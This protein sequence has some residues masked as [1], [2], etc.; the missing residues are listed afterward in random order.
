[1]GTL[2]NPKGKSRGRWSNALAGVLLVAG[3]ACAHDSPPPD[4]SPYS[5]LVVDQASREST[6]GHGAVSLGY[7]NTYVDGMLLDIPGGK[8]PIGTVRIQSVSLDLDYFFADRWS[9][10]VGLPYVQSRYNG[11][12][13]HCPTAAPPQ[14]AGQ[15]ALAQP[16]P[17][18]RFLDDGK[19]HGAWQD[20]TL[21]IA[22]HA[23]LDG[24]LVAP[25]ISVVI[26][27]HRY[28]FF[29]NAAVG[30]DLHKLEIAVDVSHQ[31]DF[32]SLYYRVI[33]GHVFTP[34][35]LG[36][37]IDYNRLD[38]ELGY[39]LNDTWTLKTFAAG[40]KGHG[41]NGGYDPTT[42]VFYHHDQRAPHNYA[43]LGVGIDHRFGE[44]TILSTTVEKLIWGQT[45]YDFK[46]SVNVRLTRNF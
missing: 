20:W 7:Q 13:P 1:M 3:A 23:D 31:F 17:E 32:T 10:H 19:T 39:F 37:N 38:L 12:Q 41:Y 45:V 24:Y 35:T 43:N 15:P 42:E 2:G 33:A 29:A 34:T 18:S 28:T 11:P 16:H 14:C 26:P 27:S 46:Y 44:R 9:A 6:Q 8:A 21:G 40:K 22:Y 36:Q 4:V 5:P 30:Q 25:S